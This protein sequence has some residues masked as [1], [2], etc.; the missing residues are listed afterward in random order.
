VSSPVKLGMLAWNQYTTWPAMRD[1]AVRADQLGY[2][3]L[4]TWDH[5]YPIVGSD[6]GPILEGWTV[7]AGWAGAT[8]R[9]R[10]GLMVG[11]NP[12]RN[13][14]LV[15]K[16]A[17]TLDH[18]SGGRAILGIGGAWFE[19]E[20]TAFGID[21]GSGFGERLDRLDEAVL[22]LRRLLAGER[23]SHEGRFYTFHDALC[24]PRPIQKK[25]PILVGGSGPKKTLR[26][27]ARYADA[28]NSG[29][30][31]EEL[32]RKDAILRERC[33]EI[34]RNHEEIER[35]ASVWMTIR[36]DPA[37]ARR[38]LG[39]NAVANG[40]TLADDDVVFVGS[41]QKIADELRPIVD[42]GF[43][44]ILIDAMA[45]YDAETL[46]RLPEVRELLAG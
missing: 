25:L 38:V 11:A 20:H 34:G 5:L 17:T 23:F 18:V 22:L 27:T 40:D 37:E 45:P 8:E 12:F 7:L 35:T 9:A 43:R 42:V 6:Q 3:D 24:E 2:D 36:D 30:T 4:W 46:E 44:H 33:A 29:G 15:A 26:T 1:A 14:A 13:P 10:I 39:V 21:F 16:M 31:A 28:W 32:R 41:P 19:T